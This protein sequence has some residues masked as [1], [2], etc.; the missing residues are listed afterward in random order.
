[1]TLMGRQALGTAALFA[2][3]FLPSPAFAVAG[4]GSLKKQAEMMEAM[5]KEKAAAQAPTPATPAEANPEAAPS[6]TLDIDPAAADRG[7]GLY[8][9]YCQKCHGL[10]MVTTAAGFFDLRKLQPTEK[11]RFVHSVTH[12]LRAMPAWGGAIQLS[13]MDDLWAYVMSVNL[14]K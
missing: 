7:R 13:E 9:A 3:V 5:D 2:A 11:P 12:G 6:A 14:R 10:N 8:K 1:M 4:P